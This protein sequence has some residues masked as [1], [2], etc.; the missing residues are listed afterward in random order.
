MSWRGVD[1]DA[2]QALI[3]AVTEQGGAVRFG[4]SRD[5]SA[6]ALGFLG[7]GEPYTEWLRPTDDIADV[8]VAMAASWNG[9]AP[10]E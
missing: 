3:F 7:D 4:C 8:L 6:L 1:A 10:A 9:E 5:R 2:I